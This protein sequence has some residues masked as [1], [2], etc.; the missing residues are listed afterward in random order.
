MLPAATS[1]GVSNELAA[2]AATVSISSGAVLVI[3]EG[4]DRP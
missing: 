1:R 3:H 2:P 4:K